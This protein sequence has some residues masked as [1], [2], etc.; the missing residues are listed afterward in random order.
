MKSRNKNIPVQEIR[1]A[2]QDIIAKIETHENEINAQLTRLRNLDRLLQQFNLVE[3]PMSGRG[4]DYSGQSTQ[5]GD[6]LQSKDAMIR[7]PEWNHIEVTAQNESVLSMPADA[8]RNKM[9]TSY[10][11]NISE[12]GI[13]RFIREY[14]ALPKTGALSDKKSRNDFAR[15]Y[16]I[17]C[18]T[19]RNTTERVNNPSLPPDLRDDGSLSSGCFWA[20]A[21]A[22]GYYAVV[23]NQRLSYD[24]TLHNYGGMKE[25][26]RS[27][28]AGGVY[29]RIQVVQPAEYQ[30]Y[31]GRWRIL[32]QGMLRLT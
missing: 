17:M 25:A 28:Y 16:G 29:D 18:F 13:V 10:A 15:Q 8:D 30:R 23:P 3:A 7:Q 1:R 6:F 27:N 26:F 14:N 32:K 12:Q 22:K 4:G 2:I 19:C 31:M 24:E 5:Q 9:H 21:Y 11:G 20:Y